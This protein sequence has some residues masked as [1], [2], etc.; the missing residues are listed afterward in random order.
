MPQ[1]EPA[2]SAASAR[3]RRL[4]ARLPEL[5]VAAL[6][7]VRDAIEPALARESVRVSDVDS[8][9]RAADRH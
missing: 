8:V 6:L 5:S 4:Q 7:R 3:V 9:L 2:V 1:R